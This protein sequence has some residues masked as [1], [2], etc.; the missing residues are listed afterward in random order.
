MKCLVPCNG[1][2]DS[3]RLWTPRCGFRIP[4]SG[5]QSFSVQL[6]FWIPIFSGIPDSQS[7]ILHSKTQ[8]FGFHKQISLTQSGMLILGSEGLNNSPN[9]LPYGLQGCVT[10]YEC[11]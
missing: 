1:I 9:E 3:L 8:D 4:G 10:R 11:L 7:C 5:F 6:G 2:Q